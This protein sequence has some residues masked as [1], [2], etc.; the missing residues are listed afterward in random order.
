M[1]VVKYEM[2]LDKDSKEVVDLVDAILE[3]VMKKAPIA[4]YMDLMDE[5]VA[6]VEGVQNIP[7]G[8]VGEYRDELAGYLVHKV[9]G[10]LLPMKPKDPV[11]D[12]V[13]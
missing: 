4:E 7:S 6:A 5:L 11:V 8:V 12:A 9:M 10:R 1:S 13:A 2:S 3:K